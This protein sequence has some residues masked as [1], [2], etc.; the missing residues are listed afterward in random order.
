MHLIKRTILI[1]VLIMFTVSCE[2]SKQTETQ[3]ITK[4]V[5]TPRGDDSALKLNNGAKWQANPETT[6]GVR[7]MQLHLVEFKNTGQND[8]RLLKQKLEQEF[9]YIF[10][11]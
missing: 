6:E 9:K 11:K 8:Y 2:H 5:E 3:Q 1:A 4:A 10:D 7:S